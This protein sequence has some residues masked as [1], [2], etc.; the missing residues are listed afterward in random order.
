MKQELYN[1]IMKKYNL[2]D[3]FQPYD[4]SK[5]SIDSLHIFP[6]KPNGGMYHHICENDGQIVFANITERTIAQNIVE[7]CKTLEI[8][9]V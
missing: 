8:L 5:I 4:L 2:T 7:D 9:F 6:K 1:F 3:S